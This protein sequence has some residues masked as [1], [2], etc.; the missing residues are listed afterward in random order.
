VDGAHDWQ[1][2]EGAYSPEWLRETAVELTKPAPLKQVLDQVRTAEVRRMAW[3][4][5][6][7]PPLHSTIHHAG[8]AIGR[9]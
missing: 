2:N 5:M 4:R 3:L 7:G 8:M 9:I 6:E 1:K